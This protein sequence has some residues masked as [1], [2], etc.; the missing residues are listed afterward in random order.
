MFRTLHPYFHFVVFTAAQRDYA[1]M[2]IKRIDPM[3]Q[4]IKHRFYRSSCKQRLNCLVKDLNVV[5]DCL[6]QRNPAVF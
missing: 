3:G 1:N 6:K 5:V 4:Y 2:V